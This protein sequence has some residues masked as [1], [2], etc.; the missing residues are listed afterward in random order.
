MIQDLAATCEQLRLT[1]RIP[2]TH[3]PQLVA[4]DNKLIASVERLQSKHWVFGEFPT[5]EELTNSTHEHKITEESPYAFPG[6]D[7][8]IVEQVKYE[9]QVECGEIMEV[10]DDE[11]EEEPDLDTESSGLTSQQQAII[12]ISQLKCL[13]IKFGGEMNTTDLTQQLCWF[14]GHLFHED[15]QNARQMCID[16]Y[17]S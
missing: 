16:L 11:E 3:P 14:H 10:V 8:E 7:L 15:L 9:K 12:L 13:S 1:I 5:V 4:T 17:F 2:A 6:G